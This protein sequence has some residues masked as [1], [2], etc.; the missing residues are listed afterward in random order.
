MENFGFKDYYT[1]SQMDAALAGKVDANAYSLLQPGEIGFGVAPALPAAYA[2]IGAVPYDGHDQIASP[3][4]GKYLHTASGADLYHIPKHYVKYVGNTAYFSDVPQDGYVLDRSFINA[5]VELDGVFVFAYGGSNNGGKLSSQ[6]NAAPLSTSTGNNPISVLDTVPENRYGGIYKA[7]KS[8]DSD[9]FPMPIWQRAMIARLAKAHGEASSSTA[10]CAFTDVAPYH[11]KGNNNNALADHA[12]T[13]VTFTS[14]GNATYPNCALTGSGVPFAKT[15]HNGQE[16]G[17][18]DLNGNMWE[19]MSGLIY[20]ARTGATGTTGTNAVALT[21]HGYTVGQKIAFGATPSSG[22]T[23]NTAV[24][25]VATVVDADNFTLTTVLER[26]ILATDGIYTGK[27][28]YM[29]KESVDIRVLADDSTT[30]GTGAFDLS[31]YDQVDMSD[32]F[33]SNGVWRKLGN[34]A[35]QVFEFSTD[36]NS[37]AYRRTSLGMPRLAGSSA[38]GTTEYGNDGIYT[39]FRHECVPLACGG[40]ND[41]STAGLGAAYFFFYRTSSYYGVGVRASFVALA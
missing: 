31:L 9:A 2:A 8:C 25:E 23:Y 24:Y 10:V 14:A 16:C 15:T 29:L 21:A 30:A 36:R 39:Y 41:S 33:Q 13:S 6:K 18:A 7:A 27:T 22:A 37:D 35:E 26:D 3:N 32:L 34:A 17:I 12:D 38:G 4:R 40:W 1:K 11:P 28:F 20:M 19:A 5:G